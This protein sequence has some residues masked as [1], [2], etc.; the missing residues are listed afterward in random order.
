MQPDEATRVILTKRI[1]ACIN[2]M[3]HKGLVESVGH[4]KLADDAR[5]PLKLWRIK[6]D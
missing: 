1:G 6:Q 4:S 5:G 2:G 3:R